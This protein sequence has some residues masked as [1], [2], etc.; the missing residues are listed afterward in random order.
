MLHNPHSTRVEN[1]QSFSQRDVAVFF[2]GVG[3]ALGF[4]GAECGDDAGA[5]GGGL[6][7]GVDVAA[8]GGYEGIG[9]AVTEF[10]DFFAANRFAFGLRNFF[11]LTFVDDIDRAFGAHHGDFRCGPG[12]IGV[13][14]NV[15]GGHDAIGAAV[16]FAG[17][18]RDFGD[19]GFGV[20]EKQ[21][22]AVL[23]D[24]AKF[25]LRAGEK[26]GHVFE[27]DE[28]NVE[29]VA[30]AH[31][32]RAFDGSVD[33]EDAGEKSGLVGDDADRSA[34][35]ARKTYDDI[36]GEMFVD[37]EEVRVVDDGVNG[38]LDVVGLLRII[39]DEG[40]ERFI[41]AVGGIGSGA[42][43]RIV[44][45]VG[46]KKAEQ[47]ANHCEA[48]GVVGSDEVRDA[49]GGVV[50][51]GAAEFFLGDFLVGDGLN[52]V[53]TGDE[54]VGSVAGH[55]NE[56]GD[57]GGIDGAASARAHDGADLRDDAAGQRVAQKNIGVTCEGRD[58]FLN[59]RAAGIV[60]TDDGSAGAHGLIHNFT[61]FQCIGFGERAAEDGE[62]LRENVDQAAVDAAESGDEAVASR[63]LLVH[64]EIRAAVAHEFV[65]LFESVFVEEKID[66][67]ARGELAGFV[68][69]RAAF[70]AATRFRF[71]I[72]FVEL[73]HAVVMAGERL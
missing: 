70:G 43:R 10:G 59:T 38:V 25:L 13:G 18:D 61:N 4:Q 67:L 39:G 72:Q 45:I 35:E 41:A 3:V 1:A 34:I 29:G 66:A 71:G 19:G 16:S 17:D 6:D 63:T 40:V 44:Y 54:H 24:A 65:Q 51:H 7:D 64:A 26:A 30:K 23:D 11:Q 46:R 15:L 14:A 28:R 21:L 27:G 53:G 57:R 22:G 52:D 69:A 58:A 56:V 73:V 20:G 9:K 5:G 47:L 50:S 12:E 36:L 49:A 48:V 42:A 55:E 68:F 32:A 33:V 60:E 2:L 37:F 62:V 31:E 8:L